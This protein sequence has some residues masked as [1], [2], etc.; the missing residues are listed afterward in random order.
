MQ[1]ETG[2]TSL[3]RGTSLH[4]YEIRAVLNSDEF[5]ITYKAWDA[6]RVRLVII[7]EY[8]PYNFASREH[9]TNVVSIIDNETDKYQNGLK[10]FLD[11]AKKLASFD[12]P[13]IIKV[14]DYFELNNTAY[15]CLPFKQGQSLEQFLNELGES[16]PEDELKFIFEAILTGI[17]YLH[18]HSFSHNNVG[19]N[20]IYLQRDDVPLLI[21]F[22]AL[23]K[24]NLLGSNLEDS[25]S[26]EEIS[27]NRHSSTDLYALG[28]AMYQCISSKITT[29]DQNKIN[30]I[31]EDNNEPLIL[32]SIIGQNNYSAQLL[33]LIDWI[34]TP[35]IKDRPQHAS[36]V[37]AILNPDLTITDTDS[38]NVNSVSTNFLPSAEQTAD[39]ED[40]NEKTNTPDQTYQPI[41]SENRSTKPK[42]RLIITAFCLIILFAI[43]LSQK[44]SLQMLFTDKE[45]DTSY[46]NDTAF[47][48][49]QKANGTIKLTQRLEKS[50]SLNNL[51]KNNKK[52]ISKRLLETIIQNRVEE[53]LEKID[54][55]NN[56]NSTK[57]ERISPN[58]L[59]NIVEQRLE[60]EL[61]KRKQHENIIQTE[62]SSIQQ[63]K[64]LSKTERIKIFLEQ[65]A[66]DFKRLHLTT[67][68]GNNAVEKYRK[69]LQLDPESKLAQQ[70]INAI[71]EKYLQLTDKASKQHN[72]G[73]AK[74]YLSKAK[75]LQPDNPAIFKV[76]KNLETINSPYTRESAIPRNM[77][78]TPL[79]IDMVWV[80][81]DCFQ[82]GDN[83]IYSSE[84]EVCLTRGY[85]LGKYEVTQSQWQHVMGDN[86]SIFKGGNKPVQNISWNNVQTFI[87]KLNELTGKNYRLPS[88]AEW[89]YACRSGGKKMKYCGSNNAA[90]IAWYKDNSDSKIH[91]VGQRQPNGLGLYDMSG[92]V[93]EWTQDFYQADYYNH[94]PVNN[95]KGPLDG[96]GHVVRGGS[97]FSGKGVLRSAYRVWYAAGIRVSYLGFR[98]AR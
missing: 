52:V 70:G 73:K 35:V 4:Q 2:I 12:H 76:E 24:S 21:N 64:V 6:K 18:E 61:V 63:K 47:P 29:D 58:E 96:S 46:P 23:H 50:S 56:I 3:P 97:W 94:S 60:K 98:L 51:E 30:T 55:Q 26:L 19:L 77:A 27:N 93:W 28:A 81:P 44:H 57:Q 95:P 84:H 7:K 87:R 82:M 39:R 66:V 1:I 75:T 67:P 17:Q 90:R 25:D 33:Q 49:S 92:N 69:V 34:I 83:D 65:A 14:S 36:L 88:E 9:N 79:K 62:Q 54:L 89:E 53:E 37:L 74:R 38:I 68:K 85:Y 8:F 15:Q 72:Y 86:S 91:P 11:Q 78:K 13:N 22:D 80:N 31:N 71:A 48:L 40:N 20:N 10:N 45:S 32:A 59:E 43:V 42:R 5:N 41:I 16:F